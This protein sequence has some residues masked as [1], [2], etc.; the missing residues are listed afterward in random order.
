MKILKIVAGIALLI[1]AFVLFLATIAGFIKS[2][3]QISNELAKSTSAGGA[4]LF[5]SMIVFVGALFLVYY[6]GK[7]GFQLL[8]PKPLP[9]DSIDDIGK[10]DSNE[11][12]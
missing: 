12:K 9:V 4:Y 1:F 2:L 3:P 8:K 7:K 6:T 11:N 10:Y 5:G